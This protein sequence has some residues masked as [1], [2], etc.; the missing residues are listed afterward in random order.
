[1]HITLYIPNRPNLEQYIKKR[2]LKN[3][4]MNEISFIISECGNH[5]RKI[6]SIYA[7]IC[8]HFN[9]VTDSWQDYRDTILLTKKCIASISFSKKVIQDSTIVILSGKESWKL[10]E[11]LSKNIFKTP[12]F[13]YRQFPN[14]E[15]DK[16]LSNI[17]RI[18]H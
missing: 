10:D 17:K 4:K 13:D 3:L 7:K 5:W 9:P 8:F 14:S 11:G 16:L 2:G 18:D 6:F 1:M 15:I 12:Y